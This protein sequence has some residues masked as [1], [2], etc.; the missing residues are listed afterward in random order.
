MCVC[1]VFG[2]V[3]H[4]TWICDGQYSFPLILVLSFDSFYP[5]PSC[6]SALS[7]APMYHLRLHPQCAPCTPS[8]CGPCGYQRHLSFFRIAWSSASKL[9]TIMRPRH[10][11]YQPS[12]LPSA[13]AALLRCGVQHMRVMFVVSIA[14]SVGCLLVFLASIRWRCM[15]CRCLYISVR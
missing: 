11:F 4:F 8:A 12:A 15:L 13:S 2:L 10:F 6:R 14:L 1:D 5:P 3:L 7:V 9:S